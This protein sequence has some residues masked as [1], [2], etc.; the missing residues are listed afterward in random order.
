MIRNPVDEQGKPKY[1]D[2]LLKRGE[3]RFFLQPGEVLAEGIKNIMV[4]NEEEALL[5]R[6]KVNY[7]DKRTSK[8]YKP[9][10]KWL[11]KGPLDY[12]PDNEVEIIEKRQAMPLAENEG[13]YVRDLRNGD[14]KLIGSMAGSQSYL[15]KEYEQL[16]EKDLP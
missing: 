15:L 7:A 5:V 11:I 4:I 9:G 10:E 3:A 1:G 16:W 8:T 12:I 6:A 2:Q 13:I 14:V